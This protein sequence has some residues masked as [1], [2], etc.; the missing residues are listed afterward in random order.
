MSTRI[1]KSETP[2]QVSPV[3]DSP[4][5]DDGL[6]HPTRSSR[7]ITLP[8]RLL[9]L[10]GIGTSVL[11]LASIVTVV[12]NFTGTDTAVRTAANPIAELAAPV[13][14]APDENGFI[15]WQKLYSG[16]I[17]TG[18]IDIGQLL[19]QYGPPSPDS[20]NSNF[21]LLD[22]TL[23]P[24]GTATIGQ[25]A[26]RVPAPGEYTVDYWVRTTDFARLEALQVLV[27]S[28][29]ALEDE[30]VTRD[31]LLVHQMYPFSSDYPMSVT[32][33]IPESGIYRLAYGPAVGSTIR[34]P[35][36][37]DWANR[38]DYHVDLGMRF[39]GAGEVKWIDVE[40]PVD[41]IIMLSRDQTLV[42]E[43]SLRARLWKEAQQSKAR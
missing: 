30:L 41:I 4:Q 18:E 1:K 26:V 43:D 37:Q 24:H 17:W 31:E 34:Q 40:R 38:R 6:R 3:S 42:A 8:R 35:A 2:G 39:A 5:E 25:A 22:P 27:F 9:F 15:W 20:P 14:T 32:F 19:G 16:A 7:T 13:P 12:T 11:L 36:V 33:R 29:A 10:F 23:D 21:N 28:E